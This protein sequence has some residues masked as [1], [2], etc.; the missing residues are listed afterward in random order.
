MIL[1]VNGMPLVDESVMINAIQNSNGLL[2]LTVMADGLQEPAE[3]VVQL[4]LV[5]Q[6]SY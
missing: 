5:Q 2:Q 4:Q 3:V 1:G 6:F